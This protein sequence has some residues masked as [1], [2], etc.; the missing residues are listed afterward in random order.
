MDTLLRQGL[1]ILRGCREA[2]WEASDLLKGRLQGWAA[3]VK[4]RR[5]WVLSSN[6][7][8]Q[9]EIATKALS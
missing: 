3:L 9:G 8:H 6:T 1:D 4:A 5:G 7:Y 2:T